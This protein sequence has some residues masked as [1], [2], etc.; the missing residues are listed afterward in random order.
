[1]ARIRRSPIFQKLPS[2]KIVEL[3][4]THL[5]IEHGEIE[6]YALSKE[7]IAKLHADHFDDPTVT[8]CITFPYHDGGEPIEGEIFICPDVAKEYAN[9]HGLDEQEELT[10]YVVHGLLHLMG[11]DDI[12][13]KDREEMRRQES[14]CMEFLKAKKSLIRYN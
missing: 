12:N 9:E 1:M 14:L 7:E 2:S 13:P 10:L 11:Y 5:G 6:V 4:L 8:D 3:L